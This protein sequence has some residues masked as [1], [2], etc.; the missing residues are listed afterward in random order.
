MGGGGS[1]L[2]WHVILVVVK[3]GLVESPGPV[4]TLPLNQNRKRG[5]PQNN[6][7]SLIR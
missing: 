6:P 3:M 5:R 7:A 1:I 2:F 4:A